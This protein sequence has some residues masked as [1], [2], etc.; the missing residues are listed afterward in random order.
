MMKNWVPAGLA[1]VCVILAS[2]ADAQSG[3]KRNSAKVPL[4][5]VA[6]VADL[7]AVADAD[8]PGTGGAFEAYV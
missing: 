1:A 2:G 4:T 6:L 5:S 3:P 7:D 8:D